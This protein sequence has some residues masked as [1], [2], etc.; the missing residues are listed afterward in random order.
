MNNIPYLSVLVPIYNEA[1]NIRLLVGEIRA[2][3]DGLIDYELIYVDDGSSDGSWQILQQSSQDFNQLRVIR[4][5][6]TYGQSIAILTGVK[7]ALGTWIVTLDGD[8]QNDPADI[9]RLLAVLK[10]HPSIQMVAGIRLK[11]QDTWLK[12]ISSRLANGI[13]CRL[14]HDD[15]IDTGCGLKLFSRQ[16]FLTLPHFNH[17]HRFL[18]ALFLRNGGGIVSITVNHRSRVHGQSKYGFFDRLM[19]GIVDLFGVMWLQRRAINA[20]IIKDNK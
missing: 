15:T 1:D 4:H 2:A 17:M 11:R 10:Q 9:P 3:L 14:L 12:R 18:A 19:V 8:G 7:A 6:S 13:R 20:E 16:A 5:G